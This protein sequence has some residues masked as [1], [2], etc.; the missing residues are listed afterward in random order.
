MDLTQGCATVGIVL[1]AGREAPAIQ[2]IGKRSGRD[3]W[4]IF[5]T[6]AG[7]EIVGVGES[8]VHA[9]IEIV[10]IELLLRFHQIV[11]AADIEA[12][13]RR[14]KQGGY[15]SRDRVNG[16]SW[17]DVCRNAAGADSD[18]HTAHPHREVSARGDRLRE[19]WVEYFALVRRITSAIENI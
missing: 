10:L 13:Q 15:A 1:I 8:V 9:D 4:L 5:V 12:G 19:V 6:E 16:A 2:E 11:I 14:W 3:D 7:K 17:E 18:R